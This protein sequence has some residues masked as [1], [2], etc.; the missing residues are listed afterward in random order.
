[1]NKRPPEMVD[2]SVGQKLGRQQQLDGKRVGEVVQLYAD[3]CVAGK[4]PETE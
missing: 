2:I 1:M 3:D 4:S